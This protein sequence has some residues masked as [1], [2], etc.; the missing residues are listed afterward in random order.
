MD[1]FLLH[2][3]LG[4]AEYGWLRF[5]FILFNFNALKKGLNRIVSEYK[6]IHNKHTHT[7]KITLE[8]KT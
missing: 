3:F 1:F 7:H 5:I 2:Y 6:F 8:N 4:R